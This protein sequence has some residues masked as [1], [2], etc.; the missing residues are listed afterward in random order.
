VSDLTEQISDV[1][2]TEA[3]RIVLEETDDET[4]K[5]VA[6]IMSMCAGRLAERVAELFTE[7]TEVELFPEERICAP[8]G[9]YRRWVSDWSV[10]E[11]QP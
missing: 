10:V 1:I 5:R 6:A 4:I 2:F 3:T 8:I 11:Q 7:V 9:T